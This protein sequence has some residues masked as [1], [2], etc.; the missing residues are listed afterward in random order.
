M[1]AAGPAPA[2]EPGGWDRVAEQVTRRPGRT[3]ALA[4]VPLVLPLLALP[5][6]EP[7]HDTLAALPDDAESVQ[8]FAAIQE[9]FGAA[10]GQPVVILF[11]DDEAMHTEPRLAVL[12]D[13]SRAVARLPG[14]ASVR[15]AAMP[16]GGAPPPDAPGSAAGLSR[17]DGQVDE[18]RAGLDEAVDGAEE[19][20]D[21]IREVERALG[22]VRAELPELTE[23]LDRAVDGTGDLVAGLRA[24]R[25][26]VGELRAGT[27]E[28][29]DGL[30]EA[31]AGARRLRVDVADP[32][33]A[34]LTEAMEAF[35]EAVLGPTADPAV[36]RAA[37]ATGEAYALITGRY[38]PGHDRE[39]DQVES[40]YDGLSRALTELEGGLGEGVDGAAQLDDG[41]GELAAGLE[42]LLAGAQQLRGGLVEGAEGSSELAAGLRELHAGVADE[43]APGAD[44]LAAELREGAAELDTGSSELDG[45]DEAALP[46]GEGR[47]FQ[48]T[49]SLLAASAEL[50]S[51]LGFFTTDEGTRTRMLVT[52]DRP[53]FSTRAIELTREIE[54]LSR[55]MVA[56]SPLS[57]ADMLVTGSPAYLSEVDAAAS[58]DFPVIVGAVVVGVAAVVAVLLR[59]LVIPVYMVATVLLTYGAAL[60]TTTLVFQHLLGAPGIHWWLPSM[61]FV[62]LVVLGVDYSIFLMS[63]V[64][65]E[66]RGLATRDAVA[67]G[68]RRTG[69]VITACGVILAG[70]FAVLLTA[71]LQSLVMLGFAASVGILLDTFVVRALLVPSLATLLGRHNWWPSRRA[72]TA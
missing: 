55:A 62:L 10:E 5:T 26:G 18:L 58:R 67:E 59:S 56:G 39:G 70:T 6:W 35:D 25:T 54:G 42:E 41:L 72:R 49:P 21:G 64:R 40:G 34:A 71:P 14:V 66:A 43:L 68:V 27:D 38:P 51:E 1:S 60:G 48:V 2:D 12:A 17:L 16:T 57:D 69:R 15:S 37:E 9:H 13:L 20:A 7:S 28:L 24:A 31:E 50:R 30:V 63:R 47:P 19:L 22:R 61:L 4:L 3:L 23:G 29:A 44:R 32:T 65:E 33:A 45:L 53:P 11:D 46:G 52:L 8:G 36:R